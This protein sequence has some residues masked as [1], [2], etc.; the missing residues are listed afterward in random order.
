MSSLATRTRADASARLR[1]LPVRQAVL[2]ALCV[3][4]AAYPLIDGGIYALHLGGLIASEVMLVLGLQVI[5]GFAGQF[6]FGHAGLFGVGAY[7]AALLLNRS[8][9]PWTVALV[10]AA[11]VAATVGLVVGLPS[12]RVGGDYLALIT[13]GWAEILRIIFLHA[14]VFGDAGSQYGIPEPHILGWDV[15][16]AHDFYVLGLLLVAACLFVVWR[17]R[18]SGLGLD[19]LAVRDDELAARGAGVNAAR[20]KVLAFGIGG[21]LAGVAGAYFAP[22]QVSISPGDF[23]LTESFNLVIALILGGRDNILGSIIGATLL[24]ELDTQLDQVSDYRLAVKGGLLLAVIF[25]KAGLP[26]RASRRIPWLRTL[27]GIA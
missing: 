13:F 26:R 24:I 5:Y 20:A 3:V 23:D 21:A 16:T 22:F 9:L 25:I 18:R 7:T 27:P 19:M 17:L 15:V 10:C 11:A 2:A 6:S 14:S 8:A 12:V 1:A 4:L